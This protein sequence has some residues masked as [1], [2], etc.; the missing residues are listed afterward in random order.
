MCAC[1][2]QLLAAVAFCG[3][4][5]Y[6]RTPAVGERKPT[7][8]VIEPPDAVIFSPEQAEGLLSAPAAQAPKK[9]T[10][11]VLHVQIPRD[12]REDAARIWLMLRENAIDADTL[13]RLRLNGLRVGLGESRG[14]SDVT[15]VIETIDGRL[16]R[17]AAPI[18]MPAGLPI[19]LELDD[20]AR[21]Q[22]LFYVGRDGVLSGSTWLKSK[23]VF[24]V[25]CASA[26]TEIDRIR[27]SAIPEVQQELEGWTW[28]QTAD[29]W[30]QAP[31]KNQHQFEAASVTLHLDPGEFVLLSVS[32][33]AD[34]E[35]LLGSAL[36]THRVD[37]LPYDS[38]IF[39]RPELRTADDRVADKM[40]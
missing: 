31:R 30:T 22:T 3:G 14:W 12:R 24:R 34:S 11:S 36:L 10:V 21:D 25:I 27:F 20:E 16:V 33:D 8:P 26:I 38:Y 29:G 1:F 39:L 28:V 35:N 37:G 17:S 9:M 4:C 32:P 6:P 40:E 23:N 13:L 18:S 15:A 5:L 19:T 2:A 7:D